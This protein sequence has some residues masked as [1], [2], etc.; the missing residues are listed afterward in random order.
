MIIYNHNDIFIKHYKH[1][2]YMDNE[3]ISV[4]MDE[5]SLVIKGNNL[6][7]I[8]YDDVEIRI[9]GCIKVI[10]YNDNRL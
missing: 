3:R 2:V 9:S 1:I 8:Y 5:Y 10:E 7:M 6:V 4:D